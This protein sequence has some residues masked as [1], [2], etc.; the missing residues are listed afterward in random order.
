[1]KKAV[2][3]LALFILSD[4]A[5]SATYN[6][7]TTLSTTACTSST[8]GTCTNTKTYY[9]ESQPISGSVSLYVMTGGS[10]TYGYGEMAFSVDS[11]TTYNILSSRSFYWAEATDTATPQD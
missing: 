7:S 3:I 11:G 6:T 8:S 5:W 4:V 2:L 1:M 10:T 9:W